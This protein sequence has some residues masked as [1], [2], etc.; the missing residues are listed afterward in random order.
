M[1]HDAY[2]DDY[3]RRILDEVT[4]IALVG[5][6]PKPE[7]PSNEVMKYLLEHGYEVIPVNPGLAGKEIH[8]QRVAASLAE[9]ARPVDM[10][11]IFRN[12]AA[13]GAVVDEALA[14]TPLPR[15]IWM[16]MG[17]RNDAAAARAE[18]NG[19]KVVMDRCPKIEYR[20]LNEQEAG[21]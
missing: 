7:R 18:A 3:L 15:V 5:A 17:V 6:S 16:Q 19:L 2:T 4:T 11:D 10:V 12:S 21:R 1:T 13:A 8:G 14:M 9:I 20:R